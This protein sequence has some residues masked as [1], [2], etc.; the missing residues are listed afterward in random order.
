MVVVG[1][2]D[3]GGKGRRRRE[4]NYKAAH[5]G[6]SR[7][8][9]PPKSSQVDALPSKLRKLISFTSALSSKP[10][11]PFSPSPYLCIYVC[12]F[13]LLYLK[14]FSC[15]FQGL[16]PRMM[17]VIKYVSSNFLFSLFWLLIQN[18]KQSNCIDWISEELNFLFLTT[19]FCLLMI[20]GERGEK[21]NNGSG[22]HEFWEF[23]GQYLKI[24]YYQ[25]IYLLIFNLQNEERFFY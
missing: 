14:C 13:R 22:I 24:E 7:L 4:K 6:Y 17:L 16:L 1:A 25:P 23:R 15:L 20:V 11:G 18:S 8:P 21:Y 2:R 3:M 9:P 12:M 19:L 10:H 5:G